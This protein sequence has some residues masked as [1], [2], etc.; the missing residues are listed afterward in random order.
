MTISYT[1][2]LIDEQLAKEHVT[3]H[4]IKGELIAIV[5]FECKDELCA[6]LHRAHFGDEFA[7]EVLKHAQ[8]GWEQK[9]WDEARNGWADRM[10]IFAREQEHWDYI[11]IDGGRE[12]MFPKRPMYPHVTVHI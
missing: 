4:N 6:R 12:L 1:K 5:T 8:N 2:A 3:V 10:E 11:E 9:A 7:A